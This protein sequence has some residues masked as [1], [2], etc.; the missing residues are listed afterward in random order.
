M[1]VTEIKKGIY[2]V[3]A[4]DWNLRSF[5]GETFSTHKGTTYNSYLIVMIK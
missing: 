1:S 3:G 2:W 4:V 5:H